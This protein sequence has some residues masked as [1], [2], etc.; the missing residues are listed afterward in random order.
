ME[1]CFKNVVITHHLEFYLMVYK[2]DGLN[3]SQPLEFDNLLN[4]EE[5]VTFYDL[6]ELIEAGK[7]K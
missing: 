4:Y 7:K 5:F 6:D 1:I 3:V 2:G